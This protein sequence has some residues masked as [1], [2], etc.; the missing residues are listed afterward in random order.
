MKRSLPFII[1]AVGK[2]FI[3]LN[4]GG[5]MVVEVMVGGGCS[6]GVWLVTKTLIHSTSILLVLIVREYQM[7]TSLCCTFL[8][9]VVAG[10]SIAQSPLQG[11]T[12]VHAV[13]AAELHHLY[14]WPLQ[15]PQHYSRCSLRDFFQSAFHK[16]FFFYFY[17]NHVIY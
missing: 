4:R 17:H 1:F 2:R 7:L 3:L 13:F 8:P 16:A 11:P 14:W 6:G 9:L 12:P 10:S 5:M 15:L